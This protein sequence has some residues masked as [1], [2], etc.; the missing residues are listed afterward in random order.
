MPSSHP[1]IVWFRD[2]LRLAAN[3]ALTRVARTGAEV[4]A[5]YVLDD[6][7]ASG[8]PLGRASRW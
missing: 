3:P 1:V 7:S 5:L 4:L 8:D 2:N 6:E